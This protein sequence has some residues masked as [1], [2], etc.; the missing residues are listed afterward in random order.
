MPRTVQVHTVLST[1]QLKFRA[2]RGHEG[3]SQLF[4]FEVDMVSTSFNLD[5]KRLLGTSLTLAISD[6]GAPRYLNGTV[7]RF[8]LVGRA[9]ETG[10]HYIYRALVQPWLWYLTRTSDCRIFQNQSVPE[11][12]D[13]VLGKYSFQFEKRLG[14][15]Y[16]P[17]EYCVQ[18]QESDFAFVS[19]LMEHEGIAYHF[20]HSNGSHLLVLADDAGSYRKLPGHARIPYRPRDRVVN[21]L[22]PCIDRW[23]VAEQITS[24][25]VMLDD[26]D[27]RKSRASLQ[28]VQQDPKGHDHATYEVYEWLGGYSEHQQGDAYAKIRLQ[29][30]QCAHELASG[31]TNVVGMAPGHLFEMTHCPREADNREYLVTETRYDL[32]EPEYATGGSS[33]SV[34]E[35]DFTVLP[36]GVPY[37]PART[38]PRPRTNGPQTATVVGPEEIWTDRFGRV[39]LQFRWDRYGQS[40]ENSSCWVRVSSN[41]AG[42]NYGTMHMPRVGQEVIVDFIGGEPDR[43]II[44][45]RVY[46]SDQMPPWELPANA[47]ASGILTRSSTGGAANQANMLRFE[48]RTGAEQILLHAERNLDVEVEADETHTTD[49]TR[50]TLIKGHE[51]ATY[52]D[53]ETRDI[54]AGAKESITGGDTRDVTGGFDETVSGGVTQR[55]SGGKTRTLSGGLDD[56]ITGGVKLAITG[57]FNGTING[58]EIRFV[59]AGR[60]DT[61]N[62]SNNVHV[63]GPSNTTVTG[64]TVHTSPDVTFNTTNHIH[65]TTQHVINTNVYHTT[66]NTYKNITNDYTNNSKTYINNYAK[67]ND[68]RWYRAGGVGARFSAVGLALDLW[69]LRQQNYILNSQF[70]A[71]RLDV[72]VF[73]SQNSATEI[74]GKGL[75]VANIGMKIASGG[76]AF[77]AKAMTVK[78]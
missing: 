7:V 11:V 38:T 1:E 10:R 14:A 34:C 67:S 12:L 40:D 53:G 56:T 2:M 65:N 31:H 61:I 74:E 9:N 70:S 36:S 3:L 32:R 20:E 25:R 37:R 24:G 52:Q 71:I 15:S 63:N 68:W 55:I 46:N 6:E 44:T 21:A 8:E 16:R 69:G 28:S 30:L 59:S 13:A 26:F 27:F 19:R 33:E 41:W 48:D 39:K 42:A 17:W 58:Q 54:T 4:E 60:N 47:T 78:V 77:F 66:S 5:L 76:L 73:R 57:G 62:T 22:E 35:F 45:G 72:A 43:P 50:T 51:S 64:P 23:R 18:Y 49:G 29:E 75:K